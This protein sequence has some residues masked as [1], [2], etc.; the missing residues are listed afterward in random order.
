MVRR[1]TCPGVDG[2]KQRFSRFSAQKL[3]KFDE[4][5]KVSSDDETSLDDSSVE[6][7]GL[8]KK[9]MVE[10]GRSQGSSKRS[11]RLWHSGK[12]SDSQE[13]VVVDTSILSD[14]S[15][16]PRS[17]FDTQKSLVNFDM[18]GDDDASANKKNERLEMLEQS[19]IVSEVAMKLEEFARKALK[20]RGASR[21]RRGVAGVVTPPWGSSQNFSIS[22]QGLITYDDEYESNGRNV[23]MDDDS[24]AGDL[25]SQ[26]LH[27]E[28]SLDEVLLVAPV[29]DTETAKEISD[30]IRHRA[31]F[32]FYDAEIIHACANLAD[33]FMLT[34][35]NEEI[36]VVSKKVLDLLSSS[37]RLASDFHFYRAALHPEGAGDVALSSRHQFEH[38]HAAALRQAL[39][40]RTSRRDALREF[41]VF[42]V[43][44]IYKLLGKNGSFDIQKPFSQLHHDNLQLTAEAWSKSVGTIA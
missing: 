19:M 5:D 21:T 36:G 44:L 12:P 13:D 34:P 9:R 37:S 11:R 29:A 32:N 17:V 24:L 30:E 25:V 27:G 10:N 39:E 2:R 22:S 23:I 1:R 41:K 7:S 16:S 15:S 38:H 40:C 14:P 8:S 18:F 42:A 4:A 35:P 43:N 31:S 20:G 26:G 33:L 6:D 3:S 28:K